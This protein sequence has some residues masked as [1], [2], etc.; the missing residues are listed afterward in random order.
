[1]CTGINLP[2]IF[3]KFFLLSK[4][5]F[6]VSNRIFHQPSSFRTFFV[7]HQ[8]R[9][10]CSERVGTEFGFQAGPNLKNY[11]HKRQLTSE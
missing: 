3:R 5:L 9:F 7:E 11:N 8:F 4:R 2:N 6:L 1:M 10:F